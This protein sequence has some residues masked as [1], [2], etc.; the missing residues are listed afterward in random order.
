MLAP[1]WTC[2]TDELNRGICSPNSS[3]S[4]NFLSSSIMCYSW[5]RRTVEEAK[6]NLFYRP[7]ASTR[8]E[9][10]VDAE[11][12]RVSH[13]LFTF[14]EWQTAV[15]MR[16]QLLS[17]T[18]MKWILCARCWHKLWPGV[19]PQNE[20]LWQGCSASDALPRPWTMLCLSWLLSRS[21][22]KY[23]H[24]AFAVFAQGSCFLQINQVYFQETTP[25]KCREWNIAVIKCMW[26]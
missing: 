11:A 14:E 8:A 9:N 2:R 4:Y 1:Q 22:W 16:S 26:V 17:Q 13:S 20:A 23:E 18:W 6:R 5:S 7:L 21:W 24:W 15:S 10:T 12:Q 19:S 25:G 3:S